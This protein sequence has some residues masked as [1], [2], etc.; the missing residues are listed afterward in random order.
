MVMRFRQQASMRRRWRQRWVRSGLAGRRRHPFLDHRTPLFFFPS[1]QSS[2]GGGNGCARSTAELDNGVF[3]PSDEA[4]ASFFPHPRH[5]STPTEPR[6]DFGPP[7]R[8]PLP[9]VDDNIRAAPA[10]ITTFRQSFTEGR[11]GQGRRPLRATPSEQGKKTKTLRWPFPP[12]LLVVVAAADSAHVPPSTRWKACLELLLRTNVR[13]RGRRGQ[14]T[15]ETECA[16]LLPW[17]S[18]ATIHRRRRRRDE[19]S[20]PSSLPI[21]ML[22]APSFSAA[23]NSS[24]KMVTPE[25]RLLAWGRSAKASRKEKRARQKAIACHSIGTGKED[26]DVEVAISTYSAGRRGCGRFRPCTAVDEVGRL[27]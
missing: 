11:K 15:S 18:P 26:E 1:R 3:S 19:E 8:P 5:R 9:F 21:A 24:G 23:R 22:E 2:N 16:W 20:F 6:H 25:R 4:A 13:R 27:A 7:S 10:A 17:R 12:A 14:G